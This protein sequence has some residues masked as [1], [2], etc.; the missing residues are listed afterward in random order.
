[1]HD[2]TVNELWP[3]LFEAAPEH[4]FFVVDPASDAVVCV[5]NSIPFRWGRDPT[6]L[7]D[8]I[9]GVLPLALEQH[10]AGVEPNTLCALQAIV[11]T[12]YQGQGHARSRCQRWRTRRDAPASSISSRPSAPRGS[13]ASR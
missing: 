9:D 7:P 13:T 5:G 10:A 3:Y 6:S 1:M 11:V 8:G 2:T 12:A 4:Q